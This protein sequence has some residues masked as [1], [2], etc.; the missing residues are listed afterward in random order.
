MKYKSFTIKNYRAIQKDLTINLKSR[1]IP[2]IGLNE[3]GKS[4]ILHAIL[5]FDYINDETNNKAHLKD[6][7]NIYDVGKDIYPEISAKIELTIDD[8]EECLKDYNNKNLI[9]L[10]PDIAKSVEALKD[11]H[12]NENVEFVITRKFNS[13]SE[14]RYFIEGFGDIAE[15][16]SNDVSKAIIS[17]MPWIIYN[18]DFASAPPSEIIIT[19]YTG[20]AS[21][22][23]QQQSTSNS[24]WAK[25]YERV[26]ESCPGCEYSLKD[27]LSMNSDKRAGLL[28][29]ISSFLSEH[30]TKE[31]QG[32]YS[33]MKKENKDKINIKLSFEEGK[34]KI[35]IVDN[36]IGSPRFFKISQRSKGFIWYYNFVMKLKFNSK[37][38]DSD[39]NTIFLLDEPG[40]FLHETAQ[41]D[42]L[43]QLKKLSKE[44]GY[45]LYTTHLP[46]LLDFKYVNLNDILIVEKTGRK[47]KPDYITVTNTDGFKTVAKE[48]YAMQPIYEALNMPDMRM[49][50]SDRNVV[51]VEG[52]CDKYAIDI[53]CNLKD[54]ITFPCQNAD[55]IIDN[56]PFFVAYS[57]P[58][59]AI[60][61]NDDAGIKAKEKATG[62]FGENEADKFDLL[63]KDDSSKRTMNKMFENEDFIR[64]KKLLSLNEDCSYEK[65]MATLYLAGDRVWK[66]ANDV[67]AETTKR[68]FT[69]LTEIIK[70]HFRK[71]ESD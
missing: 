61:D 36:L 58:Y 46:T 40:S 60:W 65:M 68:R 47:K 66:K 7:N 37:R 32:F 69:I 19:N 13:D 62:L 12:K 54:Y 3:S 24:E 56:I 38:V 20:A 26:F 4:T 14:S 50:Y 16:E 8:I 23:N 70:K 18:D 35:Q 2:F 30:L 59:C 45:I 28:E 27:L 11:S 9:A 39:G 49:V 71:K 53:F 48:N 31:W 21:T 34:L 63:P 43:K 67:I 64:I 15:N 33:S 52:I 51:L 41:K 42:L 5:T 6:I 29:D 55:S 17:G 25:I 57:V 44:E 1:L 22:Q 10:Y